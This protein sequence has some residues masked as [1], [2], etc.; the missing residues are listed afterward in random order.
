MCVCVCVY[1]TR[2]N[3]ILNTPSVCR[4]STDQVPKAWVN[5]CPE[6]SD[7]FI[8]SH[9]CHFFFFELRHATDQGH[10][11]APGLRLA[12]LRR[13][14]SQPLAAHAATLAQGGTHLRRA[15][16][17]YFHIFI[18]V[19]IFLFIFVYRAWLNS[20]GVKVSRSPLH[21]YRYGYRSI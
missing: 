2:V 10:D 8:H 12:Q 17:Q 16:A 15:G 19:F 9:S 1:S 13:R 21:R 4:H 6:R 11:V 14:Q 20:V 7:A 5:P 3:P 18:Y